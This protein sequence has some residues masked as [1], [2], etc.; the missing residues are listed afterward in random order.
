MWI[1]RKETTLRPWDMRENGR[2]K[3]GKKKAAVKTAAEFGWDTSKLQ[4]IT[5]FQARDAPLQRTTVHAVISRMRA[6]FINPS[7]N[8]GFSGNSGRHPT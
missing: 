1:A 7:K 3:S 8:R 6:N 5:L 4:K 2:L